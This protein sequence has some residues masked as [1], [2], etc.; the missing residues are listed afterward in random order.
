MTLH[1]RFIVPAVSFA[2]ALVLVLAAMP[3]AAAT[4]ASKRHP[5]GWDRIVRPAL[6]GPV[7][8]SGGGVFVPKELKIVPTIEYPDI[9]IDEDAQD[10]HDSAPP[11]GTTRGTSPM[12]AS[13]V[14]PNVRVNDTA[15]DP[16]GTTN[17]E[18]S[19]SAL[20]S[21][22]VAAWNDGKAF[23]VSP[24]NTGFAYSSNGGTSWTDGGVPPVTGPSARH[25]GDPC[26][27]NDF[28]GNFYLSDLYTPDGIASAIAVTKGTFAGTVFTFGTPVIVQSTTTDFLDKE[29]IA[30]DK[31]S[32]TIYMTYTRFLAAGG[33]QIEFTRS[34][35][36]G[37]TWDPPTVLTSP[38]IESCQGSRVVVNP[39][40]IV[41]VIYFV[42][43]RASGN[44]Y[45]RARRSVTLGLSF[46]PEI[47][48][49]TGPSGIIENYGTG[50]AGFNRARGIGFPSIATDFT[51]GIH[52][53]RDYATWEETVNF[54]YDPLGAGGAIAETEANNTPATANTVVIGQSISGTMATTADQDWFKISGT[55]GTTFTMYLVPGTG[56]GFLRVFAGGG[57]VA[58]RTQLSYIGF[59]TGLCVYTFPTTSTIFVRVLPNSAT[60]GTYTLYTGGHTPVVGDEVGRDTRD[61]VLSSTD[62]G[63][64][65]TARHVVNDDAPVFDNAF[66]EVAVDALGQVLVDWYDHRTDPLGIGTNLFY[67]LSISGGTVFGPGTQLNDGPPTNWSVA[68]S[69]LAPNM[70]DYSALVSDGC[71]VYANFAD[72]REGSADSWLAK[73]D[74]CITPTQLSLV[75]AQAQPD[76]V[77]LSWY[78]VDG[79]VLSATVERSED[80]VTWT[81]IGEITSDGSGDLSFRDTSVRPGARYAYRLGLPGANGTEYYGQT[82]VTVPMSARLAISARS[83]VRANGFVV[84]FTLPQDAPATIDVFDISGRQVESARVASTG[85]IH[86]GGGLKAG[87]YLVKLTQGTNSAMTKASLLR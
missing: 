26:V 40:G 22:L 37:A 57:A 2:T 14:G 65:W 6:P 17:S 83:D 47:T 1:P 81:Q 77:D 24:G 16:A 55:A 74:E 34:T 39:G 87:V 73:I 20:G 36:G 86:V 52:S 46:G 5:V 56:D 59:G 29:W 53:G 67:N 66:P 82:W 58:N 76:R 27:T 38:V 68:T 35:T 15:G 8:A 12:Q 3:T 48:L 62:D 79:S 31:I 72:G 28:A 60:V 51:G 13:V 61:A 44:N 7:A 21:K 32:G 45:M 49:P 25:E 4:D 18:T 80:G 10:L 19:V 11:F 43:D 71:N 42:Y 78:T 84:A 69:N 50:P 33:N 85:Q 75:Q 70:G 54:Y 30:C 23:G 63:V 9:V 64:T 41:Q